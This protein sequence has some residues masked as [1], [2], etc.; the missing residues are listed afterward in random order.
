MPEIATR[1]ALLEQVW[2]IAERVIGAWPLERP[3]VQLL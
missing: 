3:V 1:E 2:E